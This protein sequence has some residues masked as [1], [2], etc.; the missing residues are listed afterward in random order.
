MR[1]GLIAD[2]QYDSRE[3]W[4]VLSR[5]R[6]LLARSRRDGVERVIQLGD[7][8]EGRADDRAASREDLEEALAVFGRQAPAVEHVVGNHCLRVGRRFLIERYGLERAYLSLKVAGWELILLDTCDISM[9]GREPEEAQWLQARAWLDA[10]RGEERARE[11]NGAVG[12]EQLAWLAGRLAR[13]RRA[14]VL[15]HHPLC[16]GAAREKMLLWNGEQVARVLADGG[17]ALYVAG[18]DHQGG[19]TR[20]HGVPH[21]TLPALCSGDHAAWL[22]LEEDGARLVGLEGQELIHDLK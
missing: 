9:E 19:E 22:E 13:S 18:H 4:E 5:L 12:E 21:L 20:V 10:H 1:I 7:L 17:A 15:G 16:P 3:G 6:A 11:W 14:I 8:I 2:V